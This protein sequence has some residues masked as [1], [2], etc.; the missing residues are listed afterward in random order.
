[1]VDQEQFPC[2]PGY[3]CRGGNEEPRKCP[4][5]HYRSETGGK[6]GNEADCL[7]LIELDDTIDD[8]CTKC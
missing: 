6:C 5:G 7:A 8:G 4:A 2:K 3:Y 1:M